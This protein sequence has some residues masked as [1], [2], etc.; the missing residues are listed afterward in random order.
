MRNNDLHAQIATVLSLVR[1]DATEKGWG[2]RH[3]KVLKS[4]IDDL[5]FVH[6]NYKAVFFKKSAR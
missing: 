2:K 5:M 4:L 6:E 3:D 1:E